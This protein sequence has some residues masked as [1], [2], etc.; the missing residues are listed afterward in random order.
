MIPGQVMMTVTFMGVIIH[1]WAHKM[2]CKLFGVK[3][4]EVKYF[5]PSGGYVR[6]EKTNNLTA[7]F[8]I[9]LAPL[10]V[11]SL[12]AFALGCVAESFYYFE[13]ENAVL[14]VILMYLAISIGMHAFPSK[15]DMK[16]I[17]DLC[18]ELKKKKMLVVSKIMEGLFGLLRLLSIFW[19]DVAYGIFLFMAPTLIMKEHSDFFHRRLTVIEH[20][21]TI[22]ADIEKSRLVTDKWIHDIKEQPV[23][24][25]TTNKETGEEYEIFNPYGAEYVAGYENGDTSVFW[26]V[27]YKIPEDVCKYIMKQ[28]WKDVVSLNT[29]ENCESEGGN[30]FGVVYKRR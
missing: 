12:I 23:I 18:V 14:K 26:I 27:T 5:S 13:I 22:I 1:E 16:N 25:Y 8:F 24:L 19:L 20:G 29:P 11:N 9:S 21:K 7:N 30:I 4:L 3:V 17:S 10:I 15:V 6:H 2:A 28:K